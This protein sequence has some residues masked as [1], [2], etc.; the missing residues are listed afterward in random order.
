MSQQST[1]EQQIA[2]MIETEPIRRVVE[3]H[4]EVMPI[5]A[6]HGM[7]L[8][9]GGGHTIQEAAQLHGLDA[10]LLAEQVAAAIAVRARG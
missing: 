10:E 9:C 1:I 6:G 2:T 8:C 3:L 4:P 7:D 5:L